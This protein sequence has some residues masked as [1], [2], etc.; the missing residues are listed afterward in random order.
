MAT[1]V[2]SHQD[3]KRHGLGKHL[4][5][6]ALLA[7]GVLLAEWLAGGGIEFASIWSAVWTVLLLTAANAILRPLFVLFALP[8]VLLTLGL[9]LLVINAFIFWLVAM[10]PIG[11]YVGSFW[12]ALFAALIISLTNVV[13]QALLFG[14][15]KVHKTNQ[16]VRV[17]VKPKV[18]V[19]VQRGR[20]DD[21]EPGSRTIDV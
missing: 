16:N 15:V 14:K 3:N 21:D 8:F 5:A 17:N 10:L 11:L 1:R 9:G 12:W 6:L 2:L 20:K 19:N 18:R 7:L 13:T 4:P